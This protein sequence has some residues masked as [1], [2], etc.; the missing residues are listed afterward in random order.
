MTRP[1]FEVADVIRRAG[2]K[3]I[4]RYRS[5]LTWGQLKVLRA[6]ERCRTGRARWPSRPMS[7]LP[8]SIRHLFPL[9]PKSPLPEVS[10]QR[11]GEVAARPA[12]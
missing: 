6:I 8:A 3:F 10:D 11:E 12:E 1:P 7:G 9:M 5:S 4:D 2:S